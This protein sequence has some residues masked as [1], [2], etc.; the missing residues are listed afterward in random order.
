MKKW[1]YLAIPIIPIFL[2]FGLIIFAFSV[3]LLSIASEK[4]ANYEN[5]TLSEIGENEIPSEFIPIYQRAGEEY[6]INWILLASIHRVETGFSRNLSESPV[7]AIGHTQFMVCTWVGWSYPKCKNSILGNADIPNDIYTDPKIIAQYGGYGVD[8]NNDGKADPYDIEDSIFATAK[9]LSAHMNGTNDYRSAIFA[10]NPADWYV[11]EVMRYF[12][13]YSS[14]YVAVEGK[15]IDIRGNKAWIVPHTKNITSE[16]GERTLN[17]KTSFHK[18]IDIAGGRNDLGK[19][20]VAFMDGEV[21]YSQWNRGGYGYLVV[22][23]HENNIKTY[24]AHLQKQGI[25]V[26]Q[27]VKAGQ[28]I[29]YMGS[30]GNSTGVHL[31]FEIR[32]NEEPVNPRPYLKEWIGETPLN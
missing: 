29:G 26:G 17:G 3:T 22:I 18:G 28:V 15:F 8:A 2:F 27:K 9:Y 13:L 21:V 30:T 12:E 10:Y 25:R 16:F 1:L 4:E 7:G 24:Y 19:P 11:D 14:G 5:A 31:H 6:K 23:K 32:I 20:I